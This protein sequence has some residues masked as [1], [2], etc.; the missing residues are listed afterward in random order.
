MISVNIPSIMKKQ[1]ILSLEEIPYKILRVVAAEENKS[2]SAIVQEY[3][4]G[5]RSTVSGDKETEEVLEKMGYEV[6]EE[7]EE[8]VIDVD[9]LPDKDNE[10]EPVKGLGDC[11]VHFMDS[12]P[13]AEFCD[14]IAEY[15]WEIPSNWQQIEGVTRIN[16]CKKHYDSMTMEV[17]K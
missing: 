9:S 15:E 11:Q 7:A 4:L 1:V 14:G 10:I 3:L 17:E 12:T 2:M 6:D 16:L 13:G 8:E 5:K